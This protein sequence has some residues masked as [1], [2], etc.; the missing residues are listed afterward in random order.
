[1][2]EDVKEEP[3]SPVNGELE[4]CNAGAVLCHVFVII[5]LSHNDVS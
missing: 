2:S 4:F 1:M 5:N 3:K